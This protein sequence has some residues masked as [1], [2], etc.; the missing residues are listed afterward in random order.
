MQIMLL[1]LSKKCM[2]FQTPNTYEGVHGSFIN[3]HFWN[4]KHVDVDISS[5]HLCDH[6]LGSQNLHSIFGFSSVDPTMLPVR[7]LSFLWPLY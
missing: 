4:V 5:T 1:N 2:S 3:H 7:Y 6:I